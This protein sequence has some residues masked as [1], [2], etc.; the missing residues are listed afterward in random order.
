M[1]SMYTSYTCT[2]MIQSEEKKSRKNKG[3]RCLPVPRNFHFCTMTTTTTT[4]KKKLY[5]RPGETLSSGC[6]FLAFRS[7][8]TR[9]NAQTPHHTVG[10]GGVDLVRGMPKKKHACRA[11]QITRPPPPSLGIF[12]SRRRSL[13]VRPQRIVHKRKL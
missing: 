10:F 4:S 6:V 7:E 12:C 5:H 9:K 8:C 2:L 11:R 13:N 1:A 3:I